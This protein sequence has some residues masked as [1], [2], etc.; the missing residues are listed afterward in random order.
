MKTKKCFN[1]FHPTILKPIVLCCYSFS[2]S[3]S[4]MVSGW[5]YYSALLSA[6]CVCLFFFLSLSLTHSFAQFLQFNICRIMWVFTHT[7][8]SIVKLIAHVCLCV[9][10]FLSTG[11]HR[12]LNYSANLRHETLET[13]HSININS[14][15]TLF[16]FF[17]SRLSCF[18]FSFYFQFH[19]WIAYFM[20]L[21][22]TQRKMCNYFTNFNGIFLFS[23]HSLYRMHIAP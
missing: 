20:W 17:F 16:E 22:F 13:A 15:L 1:I 3:W 10:Y 8:P 2:L 4:L 9:R 12:V 14:Y 18:C 11:S 7:S 23:F 19:L 5:L 21:I 6:E